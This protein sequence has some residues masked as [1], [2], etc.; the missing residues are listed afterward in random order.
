MKKRPKR[1]GGA[2]RLSRIH[3][4][5]PAH[6]N[7]LHLKKKVF[8]PGKSLPPAF[9]FLIPALLFAISFS[10][11]GQLSVIG[12]GGPLYPRKADS[13]LYVVKFEKTK[14]RVDSLVTSLDTGFYEEF[15]R[16]IDTT[17][18][19]VDAVR[20]K[21]E[22]IGGSAKGPRFHALL[23]FLRDHKRIVQ[24]SFPHKHM[25]SALLDVK[26]EKYP[27]V[28]TFKPEFVH[29]LDSI[30]A[31]TSPPHPLSARRGGKKVP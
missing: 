25:A 9:A 20:N 26:S 22:E 5:E 11:F 29:K 3:D 27:Y 14:K 31:A 10:A 23:H 8:H 24:V 17:I 4:D 16:S 30:E 18:P 6:A 12:G 19:Y 21:R 2:D 7:V 28:V 15:K 1:N 13:A